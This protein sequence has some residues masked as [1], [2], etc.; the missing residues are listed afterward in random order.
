MVIWVE[1]WIG[2]SGEYWRINRQMP[3]SCTIAA[4]T[5]AAIIVRTY[6]SASAISFSKTRMLKVT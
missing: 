4:S 3:T 1:T 5:P 6:C 2:K